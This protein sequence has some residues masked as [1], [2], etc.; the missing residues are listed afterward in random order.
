MV[1]FSFIPREEKFSHL[2]NDAA[3]NIVKA[4]QVLKDLI[5]S[6][7]DVDKK[8]ELINTMEHAGDSITHEI[9]AKLNR[10]FVTPF[11]REDITQLT[12]SMDDVMDFIDASSTAMHLYKV[13]RPGPRAMELADVVVRTT[14]E[15]EKAVSCLQTHDKAA[16]R[17]I[18]DQCIEINRLENEADVIYRAAMAELFTDS[19]DMAHVIK[20]REI[21]EYLES[22]TDRCEDV[23]NVL[24]GVVL[25]NA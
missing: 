7:E 22:A 13:T 18:L 2:F 1:K 9:I 3:K 5:D 24:E 21:Y 17:S 14:A 12:H 20:W 6:W 19:T 25:K 11:D 4:S 23:S 10:T 16:L 15:V 8:V